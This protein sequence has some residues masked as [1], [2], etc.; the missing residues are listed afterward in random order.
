MLIERTL[1]QALGIF[2]QGGCANQHYLSPSWTEEDYGPDSR[3]FFI[4]IK[5]VVKLLIRITRNEAEHMRN[6]GMGKFVNISSATHKKKVY[7]LVE[8][9]KALQELNRWKEEITVFRTEG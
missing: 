5:K 6:V 1:S 9:P 8:N 2:S 3:P 4:F 7:W